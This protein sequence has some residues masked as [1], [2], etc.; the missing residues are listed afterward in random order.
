MR[1]MSDL[2]GLLLFCKAQLVGTNFFCL[3]QMLSFCEMKS[4]TWALRNTVLMVS[5]LKYPDK[6]LYLINQRQLFQIINISKN[7]L[8]LTTLKSAL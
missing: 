1:Y 6:W 4:F 8:L 7:L 5:V 3:Y 2:T